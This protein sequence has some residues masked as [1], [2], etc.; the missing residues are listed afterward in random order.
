MDIT[1]RNYR[2]LTTIQLRLQTQ[3]NSLFDINYFHWCSILFIFYNLVLPSR[4]ILLREHQM[5]HSF[6]IIFSHENTLCNIETFF[7][8]QNT[9]WH[10]DSAK[11]ELLMSI[12]VF[13]LINH[14]L[15]LQHP[16]LIECNII[17]MQNTGFYYYETAKFRVAFCCFCFQYFCISN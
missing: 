13:S 17:A 14:K 3:K 5:V 16:L 9:S 1:S 11:I 10:W 4:E 12:I 8:V 2:E 15:R 6:I 7:I